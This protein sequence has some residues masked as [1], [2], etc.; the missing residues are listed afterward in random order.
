MKSRILFL[1]RSYWPDTEATGQLL[2]DLAEDLSG[3]FDVHVLAGRPNHVA[4]GGY[5]HADLQ[6][7]NGVTIHRTRHSSFP[8]TSKI[9]KL[10]NLLSF[11]ASAYL[12]Q[13]KRTAPDVVVA[14]TD[15]FFLPLLASHMQ[16]RTGCRMI[17]TLQDIYP[18][19]MV[20]VGL[21]REGRTTRTIRSLLRRAYLR[22]DRIVVLSRDM[23]DKCLGWG[24]P[25]EKLT[26]IPNW[27]D[28]RAIHPRKERNVFRAEHGLEQSFVVMYSGNLGYAHLL[29]PL[30]RAAKHLRS[31]PEIQFVLI[32]DG[33]QKPRLERMVAEEHLHNVRFLPYQ[34][35]D[36]LSQSLSAADV[37]FV[38]MHPQVADCLMPSKLYGILASG[39]PVIAACPPESELAELVEDLEVGAVCDPGAQLHPADDERLA[40]EL[41]DRIAQLA[42]RPEEARSMGA[43]ARLVAEQK[44]DR[45]IQTERFGRLLDEVLGAMPVA[46]PVTAGA[47]RF[48]LEGA[49]RGGLVAMQT[50]LDS[51]RD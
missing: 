51:G 39:T 12:R 49:R 47:A 21:L 33:V 5:A 41:A 30:L 32:G 20:G 24:L 27:A 42:D 50:T 18:D 25:E 15:P 22:A 1:N 35:R 40:C 2:T 19:V 44:L 37:H 48:E 29:E 10:A 8:K 3:R 13:R 11:T 9:G 26:I 16:R 46:D 4:D 36:G 14:Q 31:R 28:T 43:R 34:P 45:R 6:Q 17:V 23:R 7:R 38:S